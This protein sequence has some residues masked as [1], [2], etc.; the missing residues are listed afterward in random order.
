MYIYI[1][2]CTYVCIS[3]YGDIY[4]HKSIYVHTYMHIPMYMCTPDTYI[5]S[6]MNTNFR[7]YVHT[8][9]YISLPL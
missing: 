9:K 8:C 5:C 2:V 7:M 6:Y 4:A 1:C 3:I